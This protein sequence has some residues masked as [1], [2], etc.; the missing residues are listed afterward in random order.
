MY[1]SRH[2][3]NFL[4]ER[5]LS[6]QRPIT[7]LQ[8]VQLVYLS[9]GWMLAVHD[10]PLI[11][12]PVEAWGYGPFIS[13]LYYA[14]K[15]YSP[16]PVLNPLTTVG[17]PQFDDQAILIMADTFDKYA[18]LSGVQL[19]RLSHAPGTPWNQMKGAEHRI[20]NDLI[21]AHFRSQLVGYG[22]T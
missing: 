16:G 20:P 6:S 3:A 4:I 15:F 2:V 17:I 18:H 7:P 19:L 10:R 5:G 14:L 12:E 9:H 11:V 21:K 22:T 8:V 1:N 13:D